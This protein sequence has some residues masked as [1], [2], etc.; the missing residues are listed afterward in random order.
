M[1]VG[2]QEK[3]AAEARIIT[4][5]TGFKGN[6]THTQTRLLQES[7]NTLGLGSGKVDGIAGPITGK[8]IQKFLDTH[9]EIDQESMSQS[10]QHAVRLSNAKAAAQQALATK[11]KP[12][13]EPKPEPKHQ[14]NHQPDEHAPAAKTGDVYMHAPE[15]TRTKVV[16]DIGHGSPNS[17]H[18][19]DPGAII[20]TQI[21]GKNVTVHEKDIN[22]GVALKIKGLLQARGYDVSFAKRDESHRISPRGEENPKPFM[23]RTHT[24]RDAPVFISIHSDIRKPHEEKGMKVHLHQSEQYDG[25]T[26]TSEMFA[27]SLHKNS[28]M[29]RDSDSYKNYYVL[30]PEMHT[31]KKGKDNRDLRALVELGA[32]NDP[33]SLQYLMSEAGQMELATQIADSICKTY[34]S[35]NR[36]APSFSSE[37]ASSIMAPAHSTSVKLP[38]SPVLTRR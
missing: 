16:L 3:V 11:E 19:I 14:A 36:L 20:Q 25:K 12:K 18:K 27:D 30:R 35:Q 2:E 8:A 24:D 6:L 34:P 15:P 13:S 23:Q 9:P 7:L 5:I 28:G 29:K 26:S 33:K 32:M 37:I 21:N 22:E 38:Q 31:D 4:L 10:A 17:K 1:A